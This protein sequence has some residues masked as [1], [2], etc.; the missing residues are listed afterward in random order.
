M[1]RSSDRTIDRAPGRSNE[2]TRSARPRTTA[3][4]RRAAFL[5]SLDRL[6][7]IGPVTVLPAH[8]PM[9]LNLAAICADYRRHRH[10]RLAQVRAELEQLGRSAS[11]DSDIV[12]AIVAVVY[13]HVD[14]T[15]LFAACASVRAP[16]VHLAQAG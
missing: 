11:V 12:E 13:S 4:G 2:P 10:R 14:A 3:T 5:A 15:V 9:R 6:E 16:L 1:S 7:A 8:G